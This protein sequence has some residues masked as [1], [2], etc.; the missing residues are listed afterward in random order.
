MAACGLSLISAYKTSIF[1]K[2]APYPHIFFHLKPFLW[3]GPSTVEVRKKSPIRF[4]A[5]SVSVSK[6]VHI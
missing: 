6:Y 3:K 1:Q 5:T 2:L 4:W